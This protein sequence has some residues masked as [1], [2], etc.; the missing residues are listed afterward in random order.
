[1]LY[2]GVFLQSMIGFALL[3]GRAKLIE[4]KRGQR[5][6]V[7]TKDAYE[8]KIDTLFVD[9]RNVI[10]YSSV[11]RVATVDSSAKNSDNGKYLVICCD[12][13]A[14]FYEVGL[15]A[16][17]IENGYSVLG[18]NYP[19][20]GQS[21]GQPY[22]DQLTSAA[23]AVMQYAFSLGFK[24]ENII[25]ASWSIGGFTI[26]WMTNHYPDVR[27]AILDACFD[28]VVPLAQQQMP[29]FASMN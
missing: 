3:D 29:K 27:G 22:P 18:W 5:A 25:L 1:M 7:Q 19:G 16:I 6:V 14:S 28:D 24:T 4:Q 8:N 9:N 20:F 21:S 17:P 26:S 15:F 12:G 2:P 13:N 11:S 23:D 10:S